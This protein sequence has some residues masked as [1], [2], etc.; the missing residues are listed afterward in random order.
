MKVLHVTGTHLPETYGG[1][2]ETINQIC[3]NSKQYGIESRV[4]TLSPNPFPKVIQVNGYEVTRVKKS[5]EIA[6]CRFSLGGINA[7]KE[8]A[9][10]AD[11]IHYH[12]PWP[13]ADFLHFYCK[14]N[15]K[16][17]VTYHSDIVRQK[18]LFHIY[19][20]LMTLFL[21]NMDR[22]IATSTNYANSSKVLKK[23]KEKLEI[24]PIGVNEESYPKPTKSEI[25][26]VQS[27]VGNNFFLFI[28]MFR[29]YKGLHFLLE[30]SKNLSINIVIAGNGPLERKL[31]RMANN[32]GLTNI[33]F[34]GEVSAVEKVALLKLCLGVVF[35]SYLRSEAFGV[36]LIEGTMYGK[37]LISTELTTGSSY[38]NLN[39]VTG[40]VVPPSDVIALIKAMIKISSDLSLS[41]KMSYS[42]RLRYEKLFTGKM[43]GHKYSSLYKSL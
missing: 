2:E 25:N 30:A 23:Y 40:I 6:S 41:K 28:G 38:I 11:I 21:K 10:W 33:H 34:V 13:F 15:K 36:S 20:F 14:V 27:I 32:L 19:K 1:V 4:F 24:I 39:G 7:F 17:I 37:P 18:F 31:K 43:M 22:I 5:F 12:Y 9:E 35:S 42:S 8:L 29:K 16:S 26:L 3:I